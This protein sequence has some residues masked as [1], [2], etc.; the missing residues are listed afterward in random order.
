VT[1]SDRVYFKSESLRTTAVDRLVQTMPGNAV[2]ITA[3]N[4][5]DPGWR[6]AWHAFFKSITVGHRFRIVPDW[7]NP[8][9][10]PGDDRISLII[11]PGQAFGTGQHESTRLCLELMHDIPVIARRVFDAGCGSGLLGIAAARM[12]AESVVGRDTDP[13]AVREARHNAELNHCGECCA[14]LC[15]DVTDE[16]GLFDGILANLNTRLLAQIQ[17]HLTQRLRPGG[18]LIISGY[19]VRDRDR[20]E[21]L[22]MGFP[23]MIKKKTA[24]QKEWTAAY[25]ER[26]YDG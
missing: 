18:F 23:G 12:G 1:G 3:G 26:G 8:R 4:L 10:S 20:M 24:V 21:T 22:Y 7:E 6:T 13:D 5:R 19:L 15:S 2:R 14:W 16:T 11:S 17:P 9:E 25:F